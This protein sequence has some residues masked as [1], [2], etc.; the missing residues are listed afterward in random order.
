MG[1][2]E[3]NRDPGRKVLPYSGPQGPHLAH[4]KATVT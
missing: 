3:A 4:R 2:R 1:F